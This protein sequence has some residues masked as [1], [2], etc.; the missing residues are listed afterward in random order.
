M[1]IRRGRSVTEDRMPCK[2]TRRATASRSD[3]PRT[4]MSQLESDRDQ[5]AADRQPAR[6]IYQTPDDAHGEGGQALDARAAVG[7]DANEVWMC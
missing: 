4:G 3:Q 6:G 2:R 5:S 7:Y 1:V